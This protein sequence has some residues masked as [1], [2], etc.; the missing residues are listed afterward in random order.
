MLA[1]CMY[2]VLGLDNLTSEMSITKV[3]FNLDVY[4]GIGIV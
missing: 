3:N 2:I 4:D 1:D